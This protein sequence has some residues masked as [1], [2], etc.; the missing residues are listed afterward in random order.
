YAALS[1]C[2]GQDQAFKLTST[3]KADMEVGFPLSLLPK[4]ITDA[5]RVTREIGIKLLWVD[6]LCLV[7]DDVDELAKEIAKM[8]HFFDNAHITISAATP[9]SCTEG[10][11][12]DHASPR[13]GAC[14]LG[15]VFYFPLDPEV[16]EDPSYLKLIIAV[17]EWQA[18]NSRTWTLQE[19]ILS[20]RL[21][22]FDSRVVRW[23]CRT[24][25]YGRQSLDSLRNLYESLAAVCSG[26]EG[27]SDHGLAWEKLKVW[28]NIVDCYTLRALSNEE[29]KLPAISGIAFVLSALS[30]D[31][32]ERSHKQDI[33]AGLLVHWYWNDGPG[34]KTKR[35]KQRSQNSPYIAPSWSWAGHMG[36]TDTQIPDLDE[37][38]FEDFSLLCW[39]QGLRV[40]EVRAL[41]SHSEAPYG[42]L[43]GGSITLEGRIFRADG[44]DWKQITVVLIRFDDGGW[45]GA[46]V[47]R[48][49]LFCLE[50]FPKHWHR[51]WPPFKRGAGF[52]WKAHG[53]VLKLAELWSR[54]PGGNAVYRRVGVYN[55]NDFYDYT[56]DDIHEKFETITII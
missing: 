20:H 29:D 13:A 32:S 18:I 27:L 7:Q 9:A 24:T 19:G 43:T 2:W 26:T 44:P 42:A 3:N 51:R 25:S 41:L 15:D 12:H 48:S 36:P 22:S 10:F 38:K 37:S 46:P 23:S 17:L 55:Y 39:E 50:F 6:S 45:E 28:C 53:L 47:N 33:V 54:S 49:G 30:T 1:Y 11:L 31:A 21:V 5:I 8:H 14:E 56:D 35:H 4:T 40:H 34:A 16:S 52:S